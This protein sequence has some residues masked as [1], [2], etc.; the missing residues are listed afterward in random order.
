MVKLSGW[1]IIE[2]AGIEAD[3][4]LGVVANKFAKNNNEIIIIS[5]DKDLAQLVTDKIKILISI[6]GNKNFELR[7]KQAVINKFGVFPT[8]IIDYLSLIGDR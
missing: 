5:N 8:Q 7:D 1:K 6:H 4:L 2:H 3:D